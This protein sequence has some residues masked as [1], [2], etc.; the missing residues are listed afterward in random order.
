MKY[1]SN[2]IRLDPINAIKLLPE[3]KKMDTSSNNTNETDERKSDDFVTAKS[4]RKGE[5][6]R[7]YLKSMDICQAT[8]DST[9]KGSSP[10]HLSPINKS[11]NCKP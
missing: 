1:D 8:K 3:L 9:M 6:R 7:R 4:M 5:D 2:K 11:I 10:S